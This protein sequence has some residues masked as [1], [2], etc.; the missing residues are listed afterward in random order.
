MPPHGAFVDPARGGDLGERQAGEKVP[1]DQLGQIGIDTFQLAQ[2]GVDLDQLLDRPG[3]VGEVLVELG[4]AL[5]NTVPC[6]RTTSSS[7][8]RIARANRL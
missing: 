7:T 8:W 6:E 4:P 3:A 5:P 1:L 2:R